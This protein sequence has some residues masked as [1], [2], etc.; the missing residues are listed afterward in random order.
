MLVTQ[1]ECQRTKADTRRTKYLKRLTKQTRKDQT[2][3]KP[4]CTA[5]LP[6][7]ITQLKQHLSDKSAMHLTA[8]WQNAGRRIRTGLLFFNRAAYL[9]IG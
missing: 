8:V 3:L 7:T 9:Y 6:E 5:T 1:T 4:C 2:F